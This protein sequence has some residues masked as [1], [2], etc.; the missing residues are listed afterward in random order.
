MP[1]KKKRNRDLLGP[2]VNEE[3]LKRT[4]PFTSCYA[5]GGSWG[6]PPPRTAASIESNRARGRYVGKRLYIEEPEPPPP[7]V[8]EPKLKPKMTLA[9]RRS[10]IARP[11][12]SSAKSSRVPGSALAHKQF[13]FFTPTAK[14]GLTHYFCSNCTVQGAPPPVGLSSPWVLKWPK[15]LLPFGSTMEQMATISWSLFLAK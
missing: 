7:V 12:H 10:M 13:H 3:R 5:N 14:K 1:P 4:T 9:N 8:E 15:G 11:V 2:R 6:K